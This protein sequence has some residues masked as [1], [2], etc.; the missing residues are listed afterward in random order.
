MYEKIKKNKKK[1]NDLPP[2]Y[3]DVQQEYDFFLLAH[4][5]TFSLSFF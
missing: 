4:D 3:N 2:L 5:D 1:N